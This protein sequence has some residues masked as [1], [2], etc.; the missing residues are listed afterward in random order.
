MTKPAPWLIL[1]FGNPGSKYNNTLHNVGRETVE[2]LAARTHSNLRRHRTGTL[3]ATTHFGAGTAD[4]A[5][6]MLAV[7]RNYMNVSGPPYAN[8]ARAFKVP[9][10]Q[11]LAIHDDLDLPAHT[12]RLKMG[13]GEGGHNGLRS[14]SA[15]LKTKDY[16]RLR[17]G[18]GRPPGSQDAARY[19]LAPIPKAQREDWQ[20]TLEQ[21]ADVAQ[22]VVLEGFTKTQMDLHS[23]T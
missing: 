4:A 3:V 7:A 20:V 2:L 21:A 22:D 5:P 13:G 19:V 15:A 12:L 18:I 9:P 1:G 6:V 11:I 23:R 8:L 17:I 14:L 16:A 10:E